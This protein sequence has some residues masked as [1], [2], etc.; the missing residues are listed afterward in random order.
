M[1]LLSET[2]PHPKDGLTRF[3]E[4]G[5]RY[6]YEPTGE[7][8]RKSMTGILKPCFDTFDGIAVA[9]RGVPKWLKDDNSKYW[10]LCNHLKMVMGMSNEQIVEEVNKLWTANGLAAAAEG[11]KMH[12]DLELFIQDM[13]PPPSKDEPPPT[14]CAAY[15]GM[16][17]WFY[18][19]QK[20]E[21][22]RCE[23]PIV[24][25]VDDVVVCCGT[26]DFIMRSRVTGKYYLLDWKHTNPKKKGLLGKRKTGA[27]RSS[28]PPDTAKGFFR[29][30][31]ATDF[32]KYSAQLLGYR[33]MLESGGYFTRDEIAGC[34]IVQIHEDLD[35][36]NVVEVNDEEA[37]EDAVVM[38]MESEVADAKREATEPNLV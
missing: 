34:W 37:F 27:S 32:N 22:W 17:E 7:R 31:E 35:K 38:M 20:L 11:T 29:D 5:H 33:Y 2:N 14:A 8:I 30:Y 13:L 6:F 36:A 21:P 25:V 23:F 12:N 3:V 26:I 18:P 4:D 28:F 1:P 15:I 10:A 16:L 19:D 24:L 9:T